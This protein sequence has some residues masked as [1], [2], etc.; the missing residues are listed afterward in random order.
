[1]LSTL[2]VLAAATGGIDLSS[3]TTLVQSL[4]DGLSTLILPLGIVG[5]VLG[6]AM[7]LIGYHHGSNT[8]RT[9]AI[10]IVVG[11]MAKVIATALAGT[12][13]STGS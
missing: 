10:A 4:A 11:G 2:A 5:I 9:A 8:I 7:V 13:G 3:V 1:M 6:A 12:T